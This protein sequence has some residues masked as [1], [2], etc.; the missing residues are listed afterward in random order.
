MHSGYVLKSRAIFVKGPKVTRVIGSLEWLNISFIASTA[1]E[2][3]K[4]EV[5]IVGDW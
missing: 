3:A 5:E 1:W 4:S 2:D